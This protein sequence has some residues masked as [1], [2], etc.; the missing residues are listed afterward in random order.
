MTKEEKRKKLLFSDETINIVQRIEN[1]FNNYYFHLTWEYEKLLL[2]EIDK[3][4]KIIKE[5]AKK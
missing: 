1:K 3:E 5:K 4:I 2:E